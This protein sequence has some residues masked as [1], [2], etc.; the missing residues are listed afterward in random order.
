[1]V[2]VDLGW[3]R[4]S[5]SRQRRSHAFILA[6]RDALL[7]GF[8]VGSAAVAAVDS[9]TVM[10]SGYASPGTLS[11]TVLTCSAAVL[12][13]CAVVSA[14]VEAGWSGLETTVTTLLFTVTGA[15]A[16]IGSCVDI[17][18]CGTKKVTV[19]PSWVTVDI[20]KSSLV[21]A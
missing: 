14:K 5:R 18:V 4:S 10:V 11:V 19:R 17:G 12:L 15:S 21:F 2:V 6:L 9:V 1:M 7:A 3:R 16:D 13:I 20:F 8:R